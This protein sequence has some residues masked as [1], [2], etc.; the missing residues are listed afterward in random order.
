MEYELNLH[1]NVQVTNSDTMK[2]NINIKE[3]CSES[4]E[5]MSP[6]QKGA[7]CDK[8]NGGLLDKTVKCRKVSWII[9]LFDK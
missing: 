7:F 4:L 1:P 3:P 5:Q 8:C 2:K 9:L 6:T